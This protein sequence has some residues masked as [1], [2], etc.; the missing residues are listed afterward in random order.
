M[1]AAHALPAEF[2]FEL[3]RARRHHACMDFR[4]NAATPHAGVARLGMIASLAGAVFSNIY[5]AWA[6]ARARRELHELSD[7][8]LSDIGLS[9]GQIDQLF[10]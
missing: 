5:R 3:R 6:T 2:P 10:R 7:R 1:R 9:R 4:R 8:T